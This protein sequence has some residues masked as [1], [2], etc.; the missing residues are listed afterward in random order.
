M[1]LNKK[2]PLKIIWHEREAIVL[3][4]RRMARFRVCR[5]LR[6]LVERMKESSFGLDFLLLSLFLLLFGAGIFFVSLFLDFLSRFG[7]E[8]RVCGRP[9]TSLSSIAFSFLWYSVNGER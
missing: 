5:R 1:K 2:I 3:Q 4:E 6:F 9:L 7:G 8:Q